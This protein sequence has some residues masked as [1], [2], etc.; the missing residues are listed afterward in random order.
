MQGRRGQEG[1]LQ[2]SHNNQGQV[3]G[4]LNVKILLGSQKNQG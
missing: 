2:G 1:E 3:A 4:T